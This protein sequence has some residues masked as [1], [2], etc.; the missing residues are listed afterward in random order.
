MKAVVGEE[1]LSAEGKL[2]LE[3]LEKFEQTFISQSAYESRTI[4][5]S[6]GIAWN[7]L[8]IYPREL[9][10]IPKRTLDEFYLRPTHKIT[11]KDTRLAHV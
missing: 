11:S 5:E 1:T 6:L 8:H 3:F 10:R 7:L 4:H 2:S 9:N